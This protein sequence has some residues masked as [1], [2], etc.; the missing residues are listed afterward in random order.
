MDI[1]CT[2]CDIINKTV[3]NFIVYEDDLFLSF[4]DIK[5]LFIGHCLI[6]PKLHFQT[7]YDLPYLTGNEMLLAIQKIGT[8]ITLAMKAQGTFIA[9]NNNVSQSIAHLHIHLVPR[10][11]GDG[12]KGFFWPRIKYKN[13]NEMLAVQLAIKE[14]LKRGKN[15]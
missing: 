10:N 7:I 8:A 2:I 11:K 6:A 5:P 4:L 14:E 3:K 9:I 12:L 13:E 1:K 15:R